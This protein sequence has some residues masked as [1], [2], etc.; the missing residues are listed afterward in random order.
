MSNAMHVGAVLIAEIGSLITRVTLV[1]S[2]DGECRLVGRAETFSSVEPPYHNAF[3]AVLEAA[4]QL[5]E[6]TG[7]QLLREGQLLIPQ[8]EERDGVDSC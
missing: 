2:V 6:A 7:R 3:F 1:D 5:A 4:A 8:T